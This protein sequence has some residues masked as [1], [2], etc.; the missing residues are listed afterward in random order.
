MSFSGAEISATVYL[1]GSA[2]ALALRIKMGHT[3]DEYSSSGRLAPVVGTGSFINVVSDSTGQLLP[4][5]SAGH[6]M[7][8]CRFSSP[9]TALGK[10]HVNPDDRLQQKHVSV[11]HIH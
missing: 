9:R 11:M 2:L 6:P 7:Y 3:G 4:L 5:V 1:C 10:L 8:L